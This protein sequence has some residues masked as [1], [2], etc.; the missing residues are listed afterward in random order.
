M[1]KALI[2]TITLSI[3]TIGITPAMGQVQAQSVLD[4][5]CRGYD[6]SDPNA[7]DACKQNQESRNDTRSDNAIFGGGSLM[8][9]VIRLFGI[10][11]GVGGVIMIIIGG[12]K[13]VLAGGDSAK[14]NSAKNTILYAIIGL[15]VAVLAQAI[16]VFVINA[17]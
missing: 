9:S 8:E 3:A 13:Y 16:I 5:A 10:V 14:V 1:I 2:A 7:P 6:L 4:P 15:V 11:A 12:F 17:L